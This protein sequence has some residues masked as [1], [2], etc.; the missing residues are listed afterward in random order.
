MSETRC[1]W[2]GSG[3]GVFEADRDHLVYERFWGSTLNG[4]CLSVAYEVSNLAQ[5]R[6]G[7]VK[8]TRD[9]HPRSRTLPRCLFELFAPD[10]REEYH[11]SDPDLL[12]KDEFEPTDDGKVINTIAYVHL[13]SRQS[14][15]REARA[16]MQVMWRNTQQK[17]FGRVNRTSSCDPRPRQDKRASI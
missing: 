6:C 9:G 2:H 8:F 13:Q 16:M 4:A 5:G 17:K 1:F 7:E 14:G 12:S 15:F 3:A 10:R 11:R